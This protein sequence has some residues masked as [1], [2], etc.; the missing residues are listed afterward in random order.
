MAVPMATPTVASN[1]A[2]AG[3]SAAMPMA[4][5]TTTTSSA[6][7]SHSATAPRA[8]MPPAAPAIPLVPMPMLYIPP[9]LHSLGIL[10]SPMPVPRA[11]IDGSP[12]PNPPTPTAASVGDASTC[13]L[14]IPPALQV[15]LMSLIGFLS[16][17]SPPHGPP[18]RF[19]PLWL[20][21]L[22]A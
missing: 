20:E 4:P 10:A 17:V 13:W 8:P 14:Y 6:P 19:S 16:L 9:A 3:P 12:A 5:P 15:A 7:T 22:F 21:H 2:L 1:S 11:A 18:P